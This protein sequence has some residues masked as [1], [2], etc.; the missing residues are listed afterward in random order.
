MWNKLR[1]KVNTS[2]TV[3]L[4]TVQLPNLRRESLI[5]LDGENSSFYIPQVGSGCGLQLQI[6]WSSSDF[7][8]LSEREWM[9][10][11]SLVMCSAVIGSPR[12][13]HLLFLFCF[14]CP[15]CCSWRGRWLLGTVLPAPPHIG[16][17]SC[18]WHRW[19]PYQLYSLLIATVTKVAVHLWTVF[20]LSCWLFCCLKWKDRNHDTINSLV[21]GET[22]TCN[23]NIFSKSFFFVL[24]CHFPSRVVGR[25]NLLWVVWVFLI[26]SRYHDYVL[27]SGALPSVSCWTR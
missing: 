4:H 23:H 7:Y 13:A 21:R 8:S 15:I 9:R 20:V 11:D 24:W 27:I 16:P 3:A 19:R 12:W 2:V 18:P 14:R 10:A 5:F 26:F 1:V 22:Q 17:P 6:L 25:S